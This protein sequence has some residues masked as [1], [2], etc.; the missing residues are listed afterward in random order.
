MCRLS[1]EVVLVLILFGVRHDRI[2]N[3][4]SSEVYVFFS[5]GRVVGLLDGKVSSGRGLK[6]LRKHRLD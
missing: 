4:F 1:V 6:K 5:F 3:G 2:R